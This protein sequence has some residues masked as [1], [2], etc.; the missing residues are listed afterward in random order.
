MPE[1]G[2]PMAGAD[3]GA[4]HEEL[5]VL[6]LHDQR[7]FQGGVK[8]GPAG[9]G[10]EFI[11][12]AEQG[13]AGDH[14]HVDALLVV[15]PVAVAEGGFGRLLLGDPVLEWVEALLDLL[16]VGASPGSLLWRGGA[17]FLRQASRR[18]LGQGGAG[19]PEQAEEQGQGT[20][21]TCR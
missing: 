7:R 15:I 21:G 5:A 14:V 1:M 6:F 19:S 17:A 4:L 11:L 18:F 3:L 9:A 13:L 16:L 12:G 2:I 20:Q 10:I 8:A